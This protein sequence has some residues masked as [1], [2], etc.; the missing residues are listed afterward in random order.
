[1]Q[2]LEFKYA[3]LINDKGNASFI[4]NHA[5]EYAVVIDN[6]THD[7]EAKWENPFTDVKEGDWFYENVRY[8]YENNLMVGTSDTMFS[9]NLDTSRGMI[10]T[11]LYRLEKEPA[12]SGSNPFGDVRSGSYYE[13]AI[14]WAAANKIVAGYGNS[15]FGPDDPITREQMAAILYRYAKY[16]GY[17]VSK[18]ADLS[19]F[20]DEGKISTWAITPMKW[21]VAET[22]FNGV[23]E[24]LLS[25]ETHAVRAQVAAIMHRFLE[26]VAK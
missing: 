12:V 10:V 3:G 23:G 20:T 18:A 22:L 16:K 25:P 19:K 15:K 13:K 8:V 5:S 6:K 17:D 21:T 11:I 9:P 4:L 1:M 24:N 7:P 2:G 14:T 26:T